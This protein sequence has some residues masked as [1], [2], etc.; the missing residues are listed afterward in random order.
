MFNFAYPRRGAGHPLSLHFFRIR[1]H[2]AAENDFV[3]ASGYA[4]SPCINHRIA[5]KRTFDLGFYIPRFD[6]HLSS[7]LTTHFIIVMFH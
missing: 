7:W 1:V 6:P 2:N 3:I 4:D 5:L